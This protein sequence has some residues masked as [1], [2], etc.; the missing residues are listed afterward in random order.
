MVVRR[1]P[2]LPLD[3][4]LEEL[5]VRHGDRQARHADTDVFDLCDVVAACVHLR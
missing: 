2:R 3:Q 4:L 1:E 5:R